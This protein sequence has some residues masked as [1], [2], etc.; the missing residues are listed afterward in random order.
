MWLHYRFVYVPMVTLARVR[1]APFVAT[2]PCHEHIKDPLRQAVLIYVLSRLQSSWERM[3]YYPVFMSRSE[4]WWRHLWQQNEP[5][6]LVCH[7]SIVT[8]DYFIWPLKMTGNMFWQCCFQNVEDLLTKKFLEAMTSKEEL[9]KKTEFWDRITVVDDIIKCLSSHSL[10]LP[11]WLQDDT[12]KSAISLLSD[13]QF[14]FWV[15]GYSDNQRARLVGGPLL[16]EI[17][18]KM[19]NST[20]PGPKMYIYS[21]VSCIMYDTDRSHWTSTLFCSTILP[22][23]DCCPSLACTTL[24]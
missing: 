4:Q 2:S 19:L 15:G 8:L 9:N 16:H 21:G 12:L 18:V 22:S 11:S 10:R 23:Q 3:P 20:K 14:F 13:W 5:K 7:S 24:V 17:V 6:N 1:L